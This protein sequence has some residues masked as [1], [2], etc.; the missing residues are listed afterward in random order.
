MWHK[1]DVMTAYLIYS[2][3]RKKH[4]AQVCLIWHWIHTVLFNRSFYLPQGKWALTSNLK[5]II[6]T[7][8]R[9]YSNQSFFLSLLPFT[10][11]EE[12][13]IISLVISQTYIWSL[14]LS[15]KTSLRQI[16]TVMNSWIPFTV[17]R[18]YRLHHVLAKD[19][20]H[21]V[22]GIFNILFDSMRSQSKVILLW[23]WF[24]QLFNQLFNSCWLK[25]TY[26]YR[27]IMLFTYRPRSWVIITLREEGRV[28]IACLTVFSSPAVNPQSLWGAPVG[29]EGVWMP[30]CLWTQ[31]PRFPLSAYTAHSQGEPCL[32]GMGSAL[33]CLA[34]H[35]PMHG[36]LHMDYA[37]V[38]TRD[39]GRLSIILC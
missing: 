16:Q 10:W 29:N 15:P 8:N 19:K 36:W 5:A 38:K 35:S 21:T 26:W 25:S 12:G 27:I 18:N 3:Q 34:A 28:N 32:P 33:G 7:Q 31:A 4:R 30:N 2:A 9:C 20:K 11:Q 17:E 14:S 22:T 1:R 13:M 39:Y 23:K 6:C 24:Q 37:D